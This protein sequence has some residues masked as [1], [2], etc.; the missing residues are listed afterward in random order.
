[1]YMMQ[2]PKTPIRPHWPLYKSPVSFGTIERV[3]CCITFTGNPDATFPVAVV[4]KTAGVVVAA[5]CPELDE[6]E[7]DPIGRI[8][9]N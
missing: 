6:A 5:L 2:P 4:N 9:F 7:F 3:F 1:M 8:K